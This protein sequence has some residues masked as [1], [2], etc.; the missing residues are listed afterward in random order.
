MTANM[1]PRRV[2]RAF[3]PFPPCCPPRRFCIAAQVPLCCCC[4]ARVP[5]TS[6]NLAQPASHPSMIHPSHARAVGS[7]PHYFFSNIFLLRGEAREPAK[8]VH[9]LAF[10]RVAV[11]A[12]PT[13]A[14][15]AH[16]PLQVQ[17]ASPIRCGDEWMVPG[18]AVC[19]VAEP[20]TAQAPSFTDTAPVTGVTNL[21]Y[22]QPR[23]R[24]RQARESSRLYIP[25]ME[26]TVTTTWKEMCT[27]RRGATNVFSAS[28]A[29]VSVLVCGPSCM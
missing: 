8:N 13:G 5:W 2:A 12:S 20:T 3:L 4:I 16:R 26:W 18:V 11:V 25:N 7:P 14:P 15:P 29:T 23:C 27:W 19:R 28:C 24:R 6:Q 1:D 22:V 10:A 17:P 9:W 21:L